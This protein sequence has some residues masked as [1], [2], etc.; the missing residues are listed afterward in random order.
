MILFDQ[1]D[2]DP[3]LLARGAGSL[4]DSVKGLTRDQIAPRAAEYDRSGELP[5]DNIRA[6]NALGLNAMVVPEAYGGAV[7]PMP[8]ISPACAR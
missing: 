2:A 8:P 4:L 1:L 3:A 5:W 7:C 6:I